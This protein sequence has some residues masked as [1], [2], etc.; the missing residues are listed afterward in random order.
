MAEQYYPQTHIALTKNVGQSINGV[1]SVRNISTTVRYTQLT[2]QYHAQALVK[3]PH[4]ALQP[5]IT[6]TFPAVSTVI[7]AGVPGDNET[8]T[9]SINETSADGVRVGTISQHSFIITIGGG[10]VLEAVG[11][12]T[13]V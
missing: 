8:V 1:W 10:A 5:G 2:I 7:A 6:M 3:G 11:E 12:P 4:F 13:I 9:V